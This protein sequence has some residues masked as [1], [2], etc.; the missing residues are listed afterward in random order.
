MDQTTLD[1]YSENE[2]SRCVYIGL[3]CV[4]ENLEE[5]PKMATIVLMVSTS[6][7]TLPL[8]R[9]PACYTRIESRKFEPKLDNESLSSSETPLFGSIN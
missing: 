5:R 8:P 1:S 7:I 3:L 6:S 2:V 4:Q 9:H